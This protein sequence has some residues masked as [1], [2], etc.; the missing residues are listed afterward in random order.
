MLIVHELPRRIRLRAAS[1]FDARLHD[2]FVRHLPEHIG[3]IRSVRANP[4]ARSLIVTYNG[5]PDTR[6]ALLNHIAETPPDLRPR[7]AEPSETQRHLRQTLVSTAVFAGSF[8]LPP[9]VRMALAIGVVGPTIVH[10]I[11]AL[12]RRGLCVEALDSAALSIALLRGEPATAAATMALVHLGEY[13][14]A[15]TDRSSTDLLR[16]ML[17]KPPGKA[18]VEDADG[19]LTEIPADEIDIDDIVVV[20]PGD[21]IPVDG[22]VVSGTAT[23]N[24]AMITGESVPAD[25]EAGHRVLAGGVLEDGRLRVRAVRV[26]S[27]TTTARIAEFIEAAL[28]TK[29]DIQSSAERLADQRIL[30]T[31]GLAAL[32]F[33]FTGDLNRLAS[34]FLVDYSC[35]LKLGAPVAIKSALYHGA[36]GG[37]LIKGGRGIE[38][39]AK[40]DT[41]VFDK[42]GTLTHGSLDVTDVIPIDGSDSQE[43]LLALLASLEEHANHPVA[44]AIVQEAQRKQLTHVHHDEVD[45]IVAHGLISEVDGARV[46]VGSRHF[47]EEHEQVPYAAFEEDARRLE[48]QGKILLYA[49]VDGAPAGIVGLR[50]HARPDAKATLARLREAG[51]GSMVLLTGDRAPKAHALAGDLGLD[52]VFADCKPEEKAA[53]VQSL[54]EEGRTVAFVGDGVNDAPALVAADVGIAMPRGADLAR[55]S[56]DVVL[57]RDEI[58]GVADSRELADNTIRLIRSNFRLAVVLNTLLFVGAVTGYA[59]PVTAAV[60][61]NSVTIGT[62]VR[63]LIGPRPSKRPNSE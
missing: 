28:E 39:L 58:A 56:A 59:S 50:D 18:W 36:K 29:P 24:D 7:Y 53:I 2:D 44:D 42:T 45:F 62:L 22:Q 31:V 52:R 3:G 17:A 5:S 20:G 10:G 43:K 15:T 25:R 32:T 12:F 41:V 1:S 35:A 13:L 34:V 46:V 49:A 51:V 6:A 11:D 40:V 4:S 57:L 30:F 8:V 9:S 26:G 61:H 16:H 23:V 38:G 54:Q 14:E 55:A 21:M 37:A 60:T 47:L 63:A 33:L 19:A 48:A 27:A